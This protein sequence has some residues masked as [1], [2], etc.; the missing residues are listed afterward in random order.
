MVYQQDWPYDYYPYSPALA[1][2]CK[3]KS[4]V[5]SGIIKIKIEIEIEIKMKMTLS[6]NEK[7]F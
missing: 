3:T 2:G 4:L 5:N 6:F 1:L 7:H